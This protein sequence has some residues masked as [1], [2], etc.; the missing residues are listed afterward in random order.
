MGQASY[1]VTSNV[2]TQIRPHSTLLCIGTATSVWCDSEKDTLGSAG[3]DCQPL[4]C[5]R[6][7]TEAIVFVSSVET[8]QLYLLS[9]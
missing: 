9:I 7:K 6:G 5:G 1:R 3:C 4:R 8:A 2:R